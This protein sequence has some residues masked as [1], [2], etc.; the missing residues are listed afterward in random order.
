MAENEQNGQIKPVKQEKKSSLKARVLTAVIYV[1][2]WIAMVALK[3]CVP[4]G[5]GS[6]G[7]DSVF[8]AVSVIGS[9]EFLRAIE[10]KNG[11]IN[12]KISTPQRAVTIAFCAVSI[13]L[14]VFIESVPQTKGSGFLAVAIAF[15]IYTMF[16][17]ATSVFD[18]NRSSVKG[19]IYC[20]FCMLYCGVLSAMLSSV[21]HIRTNSMAAI[22]SLFFL[23]VFTDSGAFILGSLLKKYIPAKLA[24]QL[25]PNK[26]VI[27]AVGG[28]IG[29]I[30]GAIVAFYIMY[31]FGGINGEIFFVRFN[32]V[33]LSVKSETFPPLLSFI[34]IGI[35]TSIMCQIG[36]LFESAVKRECGVKDMGN[37]LPGH[38]GILDRFDSML[39]SSV[40]VLFSFGTVF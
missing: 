26:T 31:F 19:T 13:P 4:G 35:C 23:T 1:V 36:D 8:C 21:N 18:H 20:I 5:W 7:F 40:V 16:L 28:V 22:L 24:P 27:G 29:G 34:I 2:V 3:W 6:L 37:L 15:T 39:Y 25:S 33:F 12:C 32:D 9:F 17:A 38:G 14:Y 11:G 30:I 10:N